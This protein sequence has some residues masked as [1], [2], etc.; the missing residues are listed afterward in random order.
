MWS[1][2]SSRLTV[3]GVQ[4][5][6]A[7]PDSQTLAAAV[8]ALK[9]DTGTSYS[10]WYPKLD[11]TAAGLNVTTMLSDRLSTLSG[12]KAEWAGFKDIKVSLKGVKTGA[13]ADTKQ[14]GGVDAS[15]NVTFFFLSPAEK[16]VYTDYSV[17]QQATPTYTLTL[18][19]KSVE[20]TPARSSAIG[21]DIPRVQSY[22]NEQLGAMSVDATLANG[23][24][25]AETAS[26]ELPSELR[27]GGKKV[28]DL[29]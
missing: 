21:W 28:A 27:V 7:D 8:D 23:I 2:R 22:L 26:A 5:T 14:V 24:V 6:P 25:T 4:V 10:G 15:G 12:R 3:K 11:Y 13:A 20:F 18:G 19:G 9:N 29:E 17:L 16:T 1:W